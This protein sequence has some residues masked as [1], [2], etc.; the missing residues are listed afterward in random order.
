MTSAV[1]THAVR[2]TV[3]AVCQTPLRTGNDDVQAVLRDASGVPFIQGSSLAGALRSWLERQESMKHVQHLFG[4]QE[5]EGHLMISDGRFEE[6]TQLEMRPRLRISPQTGCAE[7]G[8]KFDMA[9]VAKDSTFTF[10]LTWLGTEADLDM[11]TSVEQMLAALHAGEIQL[12][13]QKSNGFGRVTVSVKK[14]V[15]DLYQAEDREAWLTMRRMTNPC[16]GQGICAHSG[17]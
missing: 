4:S 12:G 16:F 5:Q 8:A 13:A 2:Y 3:S 11:L 1:F 7:H 15:F 10:A 9:H 6:Q 14:R 17:R